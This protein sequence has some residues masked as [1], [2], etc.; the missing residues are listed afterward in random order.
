MLENYVAL[1]KSRAVADS[2]TIAPLPEYEEYQTE[3]P[4][5]A[6]IK[7][8]KRHR[9]EWAIRTK[10]KDRAQF[11]LSSQRSPLTLAECSN[12]IAAKAIYAT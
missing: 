4:L 9:D 7:L 11:Q 6:S 2:A 12:A 10:M 8:L 1:N 3:D 5:R